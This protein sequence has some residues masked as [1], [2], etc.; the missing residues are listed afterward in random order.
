MADEG[1]ERLLTV[2]S[3]MM[4]PVEPTVS[5]APAPVPL[6]RLFRFCKKQ[7]H[8]PVEERP[9]ARICADIDDALGRMTFDYPAHEYHNTMLAYPR[10]TWKTSLSRGPAR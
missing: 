6:G 5:H 7:L 3:S 10:G 8:W 1:R 2:L 4:S 9:H